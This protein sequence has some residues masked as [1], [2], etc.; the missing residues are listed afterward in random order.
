MDK[1]EILG[2]LKYFSKKFPRE[3][4]LAVRENK[5]EFVEI[6]LKSLEYVNL[7]AEYLVHHEK[8]YFLHTYAMFLL[9]EFKEKRAFPLLVSMLHFDEEIS[10][11]LLGDDY[12]DSYRKILTSTFQ[13]GQIQLLKDVIE[14]PENY[15]WSRYTAICTLR[16]LYLEG[17]LSRDELISYLRE[18]IYTKLTP[19]AP[20]EVSMGIMSCIKDAGLHEMLPDVLFLYDNDRVDT[21]WYGNYDGFVDSVFR[22]SKQKE[23][24][25]IDDAIKAMEWWACFESDEH[26][27][28]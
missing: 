23:P 17:Y 27:F 22:K 26:K 4:L 28:R 8:D 19:D 21:M 12:S 24:N 25:T 6:L 14:N 5:E 7:N 3:A 9:A 15:D 18:L 20:F 16:G 2:K 1:Q 10:R 11:S 13:D